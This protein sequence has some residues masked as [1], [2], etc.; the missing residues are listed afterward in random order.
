MIQIL[1]NALSYPLAKIILLKSIIKIKK[2]KKPRIIL[3]DID[4]TV[5]NT[6]PSL[7]ENWPNETTRLASLAIFIKMKNLINTLQQNP[8]CSIFFLTARSYFSRKITYE[9][10]TSNDL[11][12]Q[13]DKLIITRTAADKIEIIK[14]LCKHCNNKKF[15][16]I[17]DL[18]HKY[19]TG[20]LEFFVDE[21]NQIK[22]LQQ[23]Y[24]TKI[25][26]FGIDTI[27]KI[28]KKNSV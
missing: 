12:E 3:I 26:Y 21:L 4:N 27:H 16:F 20:K 23:K 13:H 15:Y 18:A 28:I 19:E 1:K 6:W 14:T 10:L 24:P 22:L 8:N 17:D 11:I 25:N 5:A 7:L 2:I 9:W